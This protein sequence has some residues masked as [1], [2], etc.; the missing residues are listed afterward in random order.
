MAIQNRRL[1]SRNWFISDTGAVYRGTRSLRHR[2]MDPSMQMKVYFGESSM[3]VK[4]GVCGN[5]E[6]FR[7]AAGLSVELTVNCDGDVIAHDLDRVL[8]ALLRPNKC[9]ECG[10]KYLVESEYFGQRMGFQ[11]SGA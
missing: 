3:A 4:C 7:V 2:Y 9:A 10:S 1:E 8:A 6:R 11:I 5:R